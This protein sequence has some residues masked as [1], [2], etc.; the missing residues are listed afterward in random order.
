MV[1]LLIDTQND[2]FYISTPSDIEIIALGYI[3]ILIFIFFYCMIFFYYYFFLPH[4]Q[5]KKK[6][7]ID[8]S[9]ASHEMARATF[10]LL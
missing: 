9:F 3:Y 10:I 1:F 4:D 5:K 2:V 6:K 7:G 8:R